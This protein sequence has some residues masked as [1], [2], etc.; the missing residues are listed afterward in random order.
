MKIIGNIRKYGRKLRY[1]KL[2][3]KKKVNKT[4]L[5]E[6]KKIGESVVNVKQNVLKIKNS[7]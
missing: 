5:A 4:Q 1:L 3:S 6:R 7:R 2:K